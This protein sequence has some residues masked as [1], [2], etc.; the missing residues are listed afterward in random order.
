MTKGPRR[1]FACVALVLG[2]SLIAWWLQ[3]TSSRSS[4]HNAHL[5]HWNK[6]ISVGQ[7][8]AV[9]ERKREIRADAQ[10][11]RIFAAPGQPITVRITATYVDDGAP[12]VA[13]RIA[14][15]EAMR[16]AVRQGQSP[17]PPPALQGPSRP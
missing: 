11:D 5:T 2:G 15:Y 1:A 10:I 13:A 6:P 16:E 9:D 7:P 8:F 3:G 17:P 14:H 12:E 4:A